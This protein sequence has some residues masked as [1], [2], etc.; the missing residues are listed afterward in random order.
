MHVK[1]RITFE[2]GTTG[3]SHDA[4]YNEVK[5]HA[6]FLPPNQSKKWTRY[7][8]ITDEKVFIG[9]D[10]K[11]GL[12]NLNGQLIH[13][14]DPEGEVLTFKE[15]L[16]DF[17]VSDAWKILNGMPYFPVVG[18]RIFRGDWGEAKLYFC[19]WKRK[20]GER[21]IEKKAFI[22]PNGQITIT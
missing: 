19:G 3:E 4:M 9:V 10:F 15:D 11:T 12:F 1:F 8:L 20:Q 21:T 16:Q 18:I 22:Y 6:H 2:D 17:P 13:V 14:C 7:E 5:S